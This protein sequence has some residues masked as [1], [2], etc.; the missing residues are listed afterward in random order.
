LRLGS[1]Q[2]YARFCLVGGTG[3]V[4]DMTVLWL[5]ASPS[6]LC[7]NLTL[8]KVIAAETAILNNFVWNHLWTFRGL[9]PRSAAWLDH[10]WRFAKFNLVCLAGIV[11]SGLLLNLQVNSLGMGLCLANFV[12]IV[13]V[14]LWNFALSQ[15]FGWQVS[16]T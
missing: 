7:W 5:L 13:L 12:A 16:Q 6:S 11:L 3:L 14:S 9:G 4:V 8:S 10:V 2:R 1:T 15:R